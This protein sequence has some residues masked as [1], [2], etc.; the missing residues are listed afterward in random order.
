MP[1]ITDQVSTA[2]THLFYYNDPTLGLMEVTKANTQIDIQPITLLSD[3]TELPR[4]VLSGTFDI[5]TMYQQLI[6]HGTVSGS[7][8]I[9]GAEFGRKFGQTMPSFGHHNQQLVLRLAAK[10]FFRLRL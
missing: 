5:K 3:G 8:Y 10:R 4:D 7:L 2:Y 1:F 6:S 9:N